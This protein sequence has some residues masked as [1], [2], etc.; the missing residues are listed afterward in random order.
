M[1]SCSAS[2]HIRRAHQKDPSLF[3][4]TTKVEKIDTLKIVSPPVKTSFLQRRDTLIIRHQKDSAEKEVEIRYR[5]NTETDTVEI[6]A[7]CP[8]PEII[9]KTITK[10]NTII[11]K[12]NYWKMFWGFPIGV[13]LLFIIPII[14][15]AFII[16]LKLK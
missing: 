7:D 9:T 4:D 11:K 5:W 16:L 12:H 2:W 3:S 6:Q 14:S 8:D 1:L 13:K 15:V 10:T